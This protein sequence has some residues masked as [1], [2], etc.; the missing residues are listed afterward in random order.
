MADKVN[1][2]RRLLLLFPLPL[3]QS[4]KALDKQVRMVVGMVVHKA[5]RMA[6]VQPAVRMFV[7]EP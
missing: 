4:D 1:K 2:E 5:V 6:A 3:P 7:P